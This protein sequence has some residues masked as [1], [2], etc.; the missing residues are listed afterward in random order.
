MA[1]SLYNDFK[2]LQFVQV[3]LSVSTSL[4]TISARSNFFFADESVSTGRLRDRIEF[5]RRDCIDGL[6]EKCFVEACNIIDNN[7]EDKV[8]RLLIELM[9]RNKF[10]KYAGKIWQLKFCETFK[11]S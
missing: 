10:E 11:R 1:S 5:L 7:S 6:G 2:T 4:G 9:G 3:F 8:Q